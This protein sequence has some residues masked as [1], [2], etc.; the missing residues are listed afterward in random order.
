MWGLRD[1]NQSGEGKQIPGVASLRKIAEANRVGYILQDKLSYITKAMPAGWES[2][3]EHKATKQIL[4]TAARK[5]EQMWRR[6]MGTLR[7]VT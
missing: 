4:A 6:S 7:K 3:V 1:L 5:M 2:M